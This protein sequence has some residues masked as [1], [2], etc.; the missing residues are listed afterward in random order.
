LNEKGLSGCGGEA[1]AGAVGAVAGVSAVAGARTFC[2]QCGQRTS[3][4]NSSIPT[5]ILRPQ[6]G[7]GKVN[8]CAGIGYEVQDRRVGGDGSLAP[9]GAPRACR[10]TVYLTRSD[11]CFHY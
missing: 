7:H 11:F 5:P 10:R 4:P 3:L 6:K 9:E 2:L 8:V 1:T